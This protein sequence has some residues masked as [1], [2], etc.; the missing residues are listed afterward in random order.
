[1]IFKPFVSKISS[2]LAN[3]KCLFGELE[4]IS[5]IIVKFFPNDGQWAK[6]KGF[7][8]ASLFGVP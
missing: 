8:Y 2:I 1:M 6:L 7:G 3:S 4:N 5:K